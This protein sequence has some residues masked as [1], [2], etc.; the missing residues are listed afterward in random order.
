MKSFSGGANANVL[1][2]ARLANH[3]DV[4]RGATHLAILNGGIISLR[5]IGHRSDDFATVRT[6]NLNLDEHGKA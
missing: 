4:H 6:L 1:D 2:L 3:F 5:S